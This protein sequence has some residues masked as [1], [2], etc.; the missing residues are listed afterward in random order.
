MVGTTETTIII[1]VAAKSFRIHTAKGSSA[2]LTVA[3]SSGGTASA[4]TS[5]DIA[6]GSIWQ[7]EALVGTSA[8]T[9]YIKSSKAS[10]DVQI[11]YWT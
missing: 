7:E 4:T 8:L 6:M 3:S 9:I 1:P 11:L 2:V 5:W 10:T